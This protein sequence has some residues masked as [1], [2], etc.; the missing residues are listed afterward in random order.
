MQTIFGVTPLLGDAANAADLSD[1]FSDSSTGFAISY[2]ARDANGVVQLTVVGV[3]PGTTTVVEES[4][5]LVTWVPVVT[6]T[7]TT[8]SFSVTDSTSTNSATCF[9]RAHQVSN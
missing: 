1:L 5:N 3:A 6:N 8:G 7:A 4:S 9:Y 2:L